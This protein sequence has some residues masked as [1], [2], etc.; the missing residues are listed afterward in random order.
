ML[1]S[2]G[3]RTLVNLA[4]AIDRGEVHARVR[5]VVSSSAGAVGV[6]RATSLGLPVSVNACRS[7]DDVQRLWD[8]IDAQG[9]E[10]VV[11]AGWL[12]RLP[13]APGYEGRVLNIHPSL[14]PSFGGRGMYGHHVH[15][16]VLAHGCKL[17]G[18][19]VH[20]CDDQ[21]DTGPILVQRSCPVLE[22][23]TPE[24]LAARVFEQECI[25]Y[26]HAIQLIATGRVLI[27][28]R[29]ARIKP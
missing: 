10:L 9:V 1:I 24:T 23:D 6:M 3:G 4:S 11:L 17:S 20:F 13:I 21:Y 5:S 26:P 8:S 14:L 28:A 12:R 18:C 22:D 7:A 25:A 27:E 2:G 19:T 15:E 29:H 16:A